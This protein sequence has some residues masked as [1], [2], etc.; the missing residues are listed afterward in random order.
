MIVHQVYCT[1]AIE[2][3]R[4]PNPLGDYT[5]LQFYSLEI[6]YDFMDNFYVMVPDAVFSWRHSRTCYEKESSVYISAFECSGTIITASSELV[7]VQEGTISI[8]QK[9]LEPAI[10][11]N[12]QLLTMSGSIA[13]YTDNQGS[14]YCIEFFYEFE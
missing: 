10:Q 4:I 1:F 3:M 13:I 5:F 12:H 8:I 7:Q 6:F 9:R 2:G 11:Y 14:I